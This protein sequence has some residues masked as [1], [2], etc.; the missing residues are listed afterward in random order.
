MTFSAWSRAV[1]M[2]ARATTR[3]LESRRASEFLG[4]VAD[5]VVRGDDVQVLLYRG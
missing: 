3:A 1:P 5:L 4:G 2:G